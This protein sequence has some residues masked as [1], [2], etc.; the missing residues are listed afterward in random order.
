VGR[1][2]QR[3]AQVGRRVGRAHHV[4]RSIGESHH[5]GGRVVRAAPAVGVGRGMDVDGK[6]GVRVTERPWQKQQQQEG[7]HECRQEEFRQEES[8]CEKRKFFKRDSVRRVVC[9]L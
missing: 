6:V 8:W 5:I 1:L 4:G 3:A 9:L 7:Q 2:E